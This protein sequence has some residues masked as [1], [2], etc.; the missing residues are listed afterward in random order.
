VENKKIDIPEGPIT[1][2]VE[3][4]IRTDTCTP[5][6]WLTVWGVRAQDALQGEPQTTAYEALVATDDPGRVLV[7]ERY[8][9]GQPSIEAHTA[10]PAHAE[11][12]TTMGER[13]M[14]KRRVMRNVLA[15]I[16]GYG[17]WGREKQTAEQTT[18][19]VQVIVFGTRFSSLE[20]REEYM[21]ITSEHA[22]YCQSAELG[23]LVYSAGIAQMD[24]DRGPDIKR[25]DLV[26][27]A[28][29]ASDDAAATHRDDP[30]HVILQPK[31]DAIERERTF[32]HTYTTSGQG[33]LW[34]RR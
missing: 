3:Y 1:A 27:V 33:F 32:T 25:G 17:W 19:G 23:T 29:F 11:L 13:N 12:V 30:R 4:Q 7:F 21:A 8:A 28:A 16:D 5:Q 24:A 22:A 6:E 26:F 18:A 2:L 9:N 31:L 34:A 10:R 20:M 14:T 15:D